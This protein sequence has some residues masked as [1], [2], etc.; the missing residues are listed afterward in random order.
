MDGSRTRVIA[1]VLGLDQVS[2]GCLA[3]LDEVFDKNRDLLALTRAFVDGCDG[4][5]PQ[6]ALRMAADLSVS[7]QAITALVGAIREEIENLLK[8]L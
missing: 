1:L 3:F 6:T 8:V 2:A 5:D 7:F 4:E